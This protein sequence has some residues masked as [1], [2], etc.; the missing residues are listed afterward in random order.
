MAAAQSVMKISSGWAGTRTQEMFPISPFLWAGWGPTPFSSCPALLRGVSCP[1][2]GNCKGKSAGGMAML[3]S[4]PARALGAA[5]PWTLLQASRSHCGDSCILT[6]RG[7]WTPQKLWTP[8]KQPEV[9]Q[10]TDWEVCWCLLETRMIPLVQQNRSFVSLP[11]S[12][13]WKVPHVSQAGD[14]GS[15]EREGEKCWQE[16]CPASRGMSYCV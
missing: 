1:N 8:Q 4:P 10:C 9:G 14:V 5:A 13:T 16:T 6:P 7:V 12:T 3:C 2:M 11:W 15:G